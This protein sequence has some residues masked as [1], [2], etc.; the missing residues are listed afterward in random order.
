MPSSP[1][2][3]PVSAT[4]RPRL[5]ASVARL[6]W[7]PS[8]LLSALLVLLGVL[9][10]TAVFASELPTAAAACL[11]AAALLHGLRL[12][13]RERGRA[14]VRVVW[15]GRSGRVS[16]D[17]APAADGRLHWRGPLAL[18]RWRDAQGRVRRLAFWPDVLDAGQRRALRLAGGDNAG[19]RRPLP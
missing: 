8:R 16:V 11:A 6:E 18:L 15:D 13:A 3:S 10:A 12:A 19:R 2:S 1:H 9:A 17:D 7:Q 4:C 5:E 14:C